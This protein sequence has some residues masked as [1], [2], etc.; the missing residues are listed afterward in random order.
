[1][2]KSTVDGKV[3]KPAGAW[4]TAESR[5]PGE[6]P[7]VLWFEDARSEAQLVGG[8]GRNLALM[9]QAGFRVPPGV[10]VTTEAYRLMLQS[11]EL[12][13]K[14]VEIA[15]GIR[16]DDAKNLEE[17]TA[18][19]RDLIQRTAVPATVAAEIADAYDRLAE[20]VGTPFPYVAVRSSG[21]AEDLAEASFAGL[22]DTYLDIRGPDA[23]LKAVSDCW[24]SMWTARAVAY[25]K[26]NDFDHFAAGIAVVVQ[27]MVEAEVAGVMFTANPLRERTDEILINASWGLGEAVVSGIV[28][29]DEFLLRKSDLKAKRKVR[30]TKESQIRRKEGGGT[31]HEPVSEARRNQLCLTD[32][33]LE[34]LGEMGRL[35]ELRYSRLPQDIEWALAKDTVYLLQSRP[36]TGVAFAWE[37]D[38]E[39]PEKI[40]DE[41]NTVWEKT[42]AEEG[43]SGANT[44]LFY[45]T[46]GW[47]YDRG[48]TTMIGVYF[49]LGEEDSHIRHFK[50]HRGTVYY[51]TATEKAYIKTMLPH[52]RNSPYCWGGTRFILPEEHDAIVNAPFDWFKYAKMLARLQA[53]PLSSYLGCKEFNKKKWFQRESW[54]PWNF[55]KDELRK[56]SDQALKN[57]ITHWLKE[58]EQYCDDITPWFFN[59]RD[60]INMVV[61]LVEKWYDGDNATAA[62]DMISGAPGKTPTSREND[63]LWELAQMLRN[64]PYLRRL[65]D[66]NEG[67]TF[68]EKAKESAEGK[69]FLAS[70]QKFVDKH[71]H[72]GHS[73]RDIYWLRRGETPAVDYRVF[74]ALLSADPEESP[75]K[76]E[77]ET[78]ARRAAVI[79]D[80]V[81]NIRKKPFGS[82]KAEIFKV[83]LDYAGDFLVGRDEERYS[84]DRHTYIQKLMWL[85]VGRRLR[86]RGVLTGERDFYFLGQHEL[87]ELL[88]GGGDM[89]LVK[90]KIT[91]RMRNFDA[92]H[93]KE[94]LA[95]PFIVRGDYFDPNETFDEFD[96]SRMKG[97]AQS[98]GIVTGTARVVRELEKIGTVQ[99]DDI[100]VCHA[101]DPGWTPVFMII[102]GIVTETGGVLSHAACLSREYGLPAVQ[103]PSAMKRIPDGAAITVN[104]NTGEVVIVS[105]PEEQELMNA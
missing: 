95:P 101:T 10:T 66:E 1:M 87:F 45:T 69:A 15:N 105:V 63:A 5:S 23:L 41:E 74:K 3:G 42:W 24:A 40:E 19:I 9:S 85:E 94:W 28:T 84:Y 97:I 11:P 36:I 14:L 39:L 78:N 77:R 102:T 86:E 22:H 20:V 34:Q 57:R 16:Y 27:I 47:N 6:E 71:P 103:I 99:K 33:Q 52:A 53:D 92:Y 38:I 51:N 98:R 21:T 48:Y 55:N 72:R 58:E 73:D 59:L 76:R 8:K 75:Q 50:Y 4:D 62:V 89:T 93:K 83:V 81:E 60:A 82:I 67:E 44:P 49:G 17:R 13:G 26:N 90:A 88:E 91:G 65:F 30:G 46:R 29:P 12:H 96:P 64:S 56:L 61:F 7:V 43:L 80:V 32:E 25:R 2:E 104:G 54:H 35:V 79:E 18:E 37:E 70:Y 100:L 68:F 31:I